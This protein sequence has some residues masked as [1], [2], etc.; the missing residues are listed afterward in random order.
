MAHH[1]RK[2]KPIEYFFVDIND[3]NY[4]KRIKV[5]RA[6]LSCRKRKSKCDVGVPGTKACSNCTK[7][8]K[9]CEFAKSEDKKTWMPMPESSVSTPL[10]MPLPTPPSEREFDD[11]IPPKHQQSTF[12]P[13]LE[14][15]PT[16]NNDFQAQAIQ[17]SQYAFLDPTFPPPLFPNIDHA[18]PTNAFDLHVSPIV[19]SS[20]ASPST[21]EQPLY[22]VH[23]S[24]R[25]ELK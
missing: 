13:I 16:V 10:S 24:S 25:H 6:C 20:L 7:H 11:W 4:Y 8:N 21:I 3:P 1:H 19:D 14:M 12:S 5:T 17:P 2:K 15:P 18:V 9:P 23:L 22:F